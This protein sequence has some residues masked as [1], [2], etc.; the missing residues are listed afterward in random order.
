MKIIILDS[1]GYIYLGMYGQ[2]I[3][4][5][6]SSRE[7]RE[8]PQR[9]QQHCRFN[10]LNWFHRTTRIQC[11]SFICIYVLSTVVVYRKLFNVDL[12]TFKTSPLCK[13]HYPLMYH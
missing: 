12:A 11:G 7:T 2:M 3:E 9:K 6:T 10:I 1:L 13:H 8:E 4:E 5:N